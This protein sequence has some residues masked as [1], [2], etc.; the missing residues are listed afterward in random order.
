MNGSILVQSF[1]MGKVCGRM[2][3]YVDI[4]ISKANGKLHE[5]LVPG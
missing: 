1:S 5:Y 2:N 4:V 3:V